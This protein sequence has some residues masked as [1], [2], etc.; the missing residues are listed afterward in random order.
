V[1]KVPQP[2]HLSRVPSTV[3]LVLVVSAFSVACAALPAVSDGGLADD[4]PTLDAGPATDAGAPV[5]AG[6]ADAGVPLE[7]PC[8]G[9]GVSA[10]CEVAGWVD[11]PASVFRPATH[12][13][14]RPTPVVVLLHGGNGNPES[15]LDSTCPSGDRSHPACLHQVANTRGFVLVAPSG[16]RVGPMSPQRQWN[17]GGG[18]TGWHCVGAQACAAGIDDAAYLDAVLDGLERWM[19]VD[20]GAVFLTGLSNGAALAHRLACERA[21]RFAA[22]APVGGANQF[23]TTRPCTP[24]R[25][26]ALLHIHG[27]QDLC[28]TYDTSGNTCLGVMVGRKVGAVD[29]TSAWATRNGCTGGPLETV[30]ADVDGDGR[31]TTALSWQGCAV[32][33]TLLRLEGAGHTWPNGRQ[34]LPAADIGPTARDFGSERLW[35]FFARNRR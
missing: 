31:F 18:S 15:G 10:P 20:R 21:D 14:T 28:W 6:A 26:V 12:D 1:T 27:T 13:V 25:P 30:E 34:Y 8:T 23:A 16:T 19:R 3:R 32:E 4:T 24:S 9:P 22:L 29:S 5:D 11:R 35:D 7:P 17:A 2:V 33:T